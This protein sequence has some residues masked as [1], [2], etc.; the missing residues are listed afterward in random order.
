MLNISSILN[1]KEI[2]WCHNHH[3]RRNEKLALTKAIA[4]RMPLEG[5]FIATNPI[6]SCQIYQYINQRRCKGN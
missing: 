5:V 1:G 4:F 2:D 3:L 6:N